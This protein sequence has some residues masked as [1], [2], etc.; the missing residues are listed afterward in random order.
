MKRD[1]LYTVGGNIRAFGGKK[2]RECGCAGNIFDGGGLLEG[3][4]VPQGFSVSQLGTFTYPTLTSS[5]P[6]NGFRGIDPSRLPSK[7][8]SSIDFGGTMSGIV[9]AISP[10]L[11]N[12]IGGGYSTGGVGEGISTVG[13]VVGDA[14]GPVA[15]SIVKVGSAI[16]GGLANRAFG[17]KENKQ[18]IAAIQNNSANLRNTGNVLAGASTTGDLL[19][20]AGQ[21]GGSMGFGST[22]LVKGGWFSKGKAK[23]KAQKFLNEENSALSMQSQGLATGAERV[24]SIQDN[25]IMGN[26]AAFGGPLGFGYDDT[27]P[28]VDYDFMNSYL[29]NK[30]RQAEMKNK[31]GGINSLSA[32]VFS[33]GGIEIKHPGRLTRLKERTGKT[34]AELWAEGKPEVR[35]MITFARNARAWSKANGGKLHKDGVSV[36]ENVLCGGGR[37]FDLGGDIQM[38]GGDYS[39]GKVYDVSEKEANRLKAMGYEFTIVE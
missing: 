3:A 17:T 7:T 37:M 30:Q 12:A 34:E 4:F 32:N 24:D 6:L 19:S 5:N 23:R 35:K 10:M 21:M 2:T 22:D 31:A 26:F 39:V 20:S 9:S 8:K 1:K 33:N 15:G 28:A 13:N 18:N 27:M 11:T 36:P 25:N 38:D 29:L 16:V 14:L